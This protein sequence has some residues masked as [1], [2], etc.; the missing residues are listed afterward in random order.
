MTTFD[1]LKLTKPLLRALDELGFTA[2][3]PIQEKVFPVI[4]SGK[5]V[6]GIAQTGTGKTLAYLLPLL[7]DLSWSEEGFPRILVLVPTRELV[8]Q[9]VEQCQSYAKYMNVRVLGVY[10]GSNMAPQK[11]AVA[12]GTDILVGTPGRLYDLV[13]SGS[14]K[15]KSVKKLVIDEVDVMLDM[16]FRYQLNNLFE[17]LPEKRQNLMFSATMTEEAA[18]LIEDFFIEPERISVALSGTPLENIEQ[19]AYSVFNFLT[20]VRLLAHLLEDQ[21]TFQKVLVFA[22]SKK[23][24]D[25]IFSLISE[26]FYGEMGI[27]HAN[28]S[29]NF[30]FRTMD[31]FEQGRIR[32]LLTT[33]VMARGLDMDDI[34]HVISFDVPRFPENYIHR[35][36]RTGRATKKGHAI[37]FYTTK[38][39][40]YKDAVEE[41]M[42]MKIPEMGF[43]VEV[44]LNYEMTREEKLGEGVR[45]SAKRNERKRD[46]GPA[47]HEKKEKN[48]KVNL[49]GA[50]RRK[51]K[52]KYKRPKTRGTKKK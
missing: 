49:G 36:G 26:R 48:R 5:N 21:E 17:L 52:A 32:I 14:L 40:K 43:P 51:L 25:Y 18:E 9:V 29:Q 3:T 37:L 28:K 42:K 24:A 23:N 19:S 11:L 50:Y 7:R 34:T 38:E 30:R 31:D 2:T 39:S 44:E 35:I 10:G 22:P 27:L 15:L 12:D 33:D 1:E 8:Q 13:L 46:I 45:K 16:G 20:K 6:V 4:L 47:F 41:L